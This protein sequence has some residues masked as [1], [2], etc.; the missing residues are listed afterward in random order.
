RSSEAVLQPPLPVRNAEQRLSPLIWHSVLFTIDCRPDRIRLLLLP[1]TGETGGELPAQALIAL[2]EPFSGRERA[3]AGPFLDDQSGAGAQHKGFSRSCDQ[4][5]LNETRLA[6]SV[7]D[8][9]CGLLV[10]RWPG[11]EYVGYKGLG[12]T[13]I[14]REPA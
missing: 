12:I 9:L 14:E 5:E 7:V 6:S 10:V 2:W 11:P 3:S 13:V 1:L 4:R 8:A